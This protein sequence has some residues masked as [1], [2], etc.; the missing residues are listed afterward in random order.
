[1]K[2]SLLGLIALLA[3]GCV[4]GKN[5]GEKEGADYAPKIAATPQVF[6]ADFDGD[7]V[8]DTARIVSTASIVSVEIDATGSR[9]MQTAA[10]VRQILTFSVG[11][12][13]TDSFCGREISATLEE[14][15]LPLEEWGCTSSSQNHNCGELIEASGI[16][17]KAAERGMKGLRLDD[18]KC[19]AFHIYFDPIAKSFNYWRR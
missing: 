6:R 5:L 7:G 3:F 18:G 4:A 16:I 1:M 13:S 2:A 15:S 8:V 14:P 12:Q 9:A 17:Q 11:K 10:A 19:D